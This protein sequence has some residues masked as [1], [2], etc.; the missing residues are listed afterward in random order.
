[1]VYLIQHVCGQLNGVMAVCSNTKRLVIRKR[2][3]IC[4]ASLS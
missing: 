4:K 1:M 3:H 2:L